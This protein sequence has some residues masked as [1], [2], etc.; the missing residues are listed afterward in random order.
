VRTNAD[1]WY[2]ASVPAGSV[3]LV[4]DR[5][6]ERGCPYCP[7]GFC[8]GMTTLQVSHPRYAPRNEIDGRTELYVPLQLHR[9]DFSL[10]PLD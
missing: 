2:E 8:I 1:G 5:R 10:M 9:I 6:P 7:T 3:N 4:L